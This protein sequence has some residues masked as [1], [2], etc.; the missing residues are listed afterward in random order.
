MLA[1]DKSGNDDFSLPYIQGCAKPL[2]NFLSDNFGSGVW[3]TF[4]TAVG[5]LRSQ[6]AIEAIWHRDMTEA[7]FFDPSL[8]WISFPTAD[9]TRLP[10]ASLPQISVL[11]DH[12]CTR[13]LVAAVS[14][15]SSALS[16][17]ALLAVLP[18]ESRD[19]AGKL[20]SDMADLIKQS[21]TAMGLFLRVLTLLEAKS[22][23]SESDRVLV[24]A[25]VDQCLHRL[26]L[27]AK[28]V[29]TTVRTDQIIPGGILTDV[30]LIE[31]NYVDLIMEW[32]SR[33]AG[34][35]T[36]PD[37]PKVVLSNSR[38]RLRQVAIIAA[39]YEKSMR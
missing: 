4:H 19:R 25:F 37:L 34:A 5:A 14:S 16:L 22:E 13:L 12:I 20:K 21:A 39:R 6:A 30:R 2:F 3:P 8:T 1:I 10:S 33:L 26:D 9:E 17:K 36:W 28:F 29:A 18:H 38:S 7:P 15:S 24:R 35:E 32:Q 27:I 31:K 23:S 11:N